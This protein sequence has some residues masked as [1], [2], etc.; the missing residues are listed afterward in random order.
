MKEVNER[1]IKALS[2]N[3]ARFYILD[4]K[5]L[6]ILLGLVRERIV[7]V[8]L[9]WSRST[10]NSVIKVSLLIISDEHRECNVVGI[11]CL[12]T[13]LS[14]SGAMFLR[15]SGHTSPRMGDPSRQ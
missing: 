3:E 11:F 1:E 8:V 15:I 5:R 4:S 13:P 14:H 9:M 10:A 2:D 6:F 7:E 12:L